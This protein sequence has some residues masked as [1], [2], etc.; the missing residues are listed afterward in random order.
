MA[1]QKWH[2]SL[3]LLLVGELG[4]TTILP[5]KLQA[6][7]VPATIGNPIPTNTTLS[8]TFDPP[9]EGKPADTAGGASR[10]GG[11]CLND[12]RDTGPSITPVKP[13]HHSGLTVASHPTFFVYVPQT[14]AKQALFVIKDEIEDYFYQKNIPI[15]TSAGI[16]S[17]KLPN[18]AP[19]LKIGKTYQWSFIMICGE[20]IRPD[21]PAVVGQIGRIAP[22]PELL[23]QIKTASPLQR[24]ALY[25]KK[26]IWYDTIAS[27][28]E[29]RRSQP[30][31]STL[32]ATWEK[33]LKS[34]GLEAIA[35]KPL[36][37]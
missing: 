16:V 32:A 34:V 3:T 21:S 5:T 4:L 1:R 14:S 7:S 37:Q 35:T 20:V 36:L 26:G 17:F 15:P 11:I 25:G 6:Q 23:R 28:A 31:D 30:N 29:Q 2:L 9:G 27:L 10:D 13:V 8:V 22:N 33:L 12:S 19:E 24:A 18:D